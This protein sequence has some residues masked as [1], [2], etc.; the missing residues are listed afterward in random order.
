MIDQ[1]LHLRAH[2]ER[3][4]PWDRARERRVLARALATRRRRTRL[5]WAL[6]LT[7]AMAITFVAGRALPRA[8]V[9]SD[10]AGP[11]LASPAPD[12]DGPPGSESDAKQTESPPLGGFAGTGGHGG[13]GSTGHGG[14][15]GTG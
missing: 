6:E 8:P 3:D 10:E 14:S 13:T 9:E 1:H 7:A 4:V 15:A 12:P 2:T 5:R 11:A